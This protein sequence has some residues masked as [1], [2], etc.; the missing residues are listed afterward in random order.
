LTCFVS[1]YAGESDSNVFTGS[2]YMSYSITSGSSSSSSD[3]CFAG[4]ETVQLESGEFKAI[5]DVVVGDSILASD[6]SGNTKFSNVIAVPHGPNSVS[7]E[8]VQLTVASGADIKMTPEHLVMVSKGCVAS[9]SSLMSAST[10]ESGMCLVSTSGMEAVEKV[11][12]V[13]G[14]GVYSVVTEEEFVVVNGFVASPFAVNHA[15]ANAFYNVVRAVPALM[16]FSLVKRATD[17]FGSLVT[18]FSA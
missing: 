5:S 15:V 6:A 13:Q 8:F 17:I 4:S 1:S 3:S 14:R 2:A 10:V 12:V 18:A 11:A 9:E 7:A 16:N